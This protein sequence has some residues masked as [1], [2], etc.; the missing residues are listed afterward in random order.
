MTDPFC[1]DCHSVVTQL[2]FSCHSV[3][4]QLLFNRKTINDYRMTAD[5]VHRS[6]GAGARPN[7]PPPLKLRRAKCEA[8]DARLCAPEPW[9]RCK[10]K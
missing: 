7:D 4:I 10:A 6:L 3:V 5:F 9:R 1:W 2:S 8:N